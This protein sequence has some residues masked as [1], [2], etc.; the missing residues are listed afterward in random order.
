[1][2][3]TISYPYYEE[4]H[5]IKLA[6]DAIP[7]AIKLAKCYIKERRLPDAAIDL[8]DR[9]MAVVKWRKATKDEVEALYSGFWGVGWRE[10]RT[11]PWVNSM[12]WNGF[13]G[14]KQESVMFYSSSWK[15]KRILI[16]L[17]RW[18]V[19]RN[20][21]KFVKTG[22]TC[23]GE[24]EIVEKEY[25]VLSLRTKQEYRWE[26]LQSHGERENSWTW[27]VFSQ[28]VVSVGRDHAVKAVSSNSR[29]AVERTSK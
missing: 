14:Q 7:E 21:R 22:R 29:I 24:K 27:K 5:G 18:R 1:M 28:R 20:I 26:E 13:S 17:N 19:D 2:V 10:Q 16:N 3:A 23:R 11:K 15:K 8:I 25:H 9:T 6:P 4:H 12:N